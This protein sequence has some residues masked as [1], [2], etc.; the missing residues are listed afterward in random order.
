MAAFRAAT[1]AASD[2]GG[3]RPTTPPAE[4]GSGL[5][6]EEA[7]KT[8]VAGGPTTDNIRMDAMEPRVTAAAGGGADSTRRI[9]TTA[10]V[11]VT[12]PGAAMPA[13]RDP[14]PDP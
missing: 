12:D 5:R 14:V 3:G 1:D 4:A 13:D 6:Y 7:A 8:V 11:K 10:A 2:T 9:R